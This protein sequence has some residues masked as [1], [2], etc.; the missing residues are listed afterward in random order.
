MP[1]KKDPSEHKKN[2]RYHTPTDETRAKVEHLAALGQRQPDIALVMKLNI[3]TLTKHYPYELRAGI[4]IANSKVAGTLYSKAIAGDVTSMIFWLKTR[5]GWSTVERLH[6]KEDT[7]AAE[8]VLSNLDELD[9]SQLRQLHDIAK[10]LEDGAGS[11]TVPNGAVNGS[12][13]RN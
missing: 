2:S 11:K 10:A 9:V 1:A 4:I 13:S 12:V 5:A 3:K 6:V 7:K 8:P